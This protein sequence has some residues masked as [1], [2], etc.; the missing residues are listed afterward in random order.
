MSDKPTMVRLMPEIRDIAKA[1]AAI[2]NRSMANYVEN[3]ILKD[4]A[5]K[6]AEK[7]LS[8]VQNG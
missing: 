1:N 7:A 6:M 8:E 3:L 2:E 5:R 4:N